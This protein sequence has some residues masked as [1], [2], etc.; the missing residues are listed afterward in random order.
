MFKNYVV[1]AFRNLKKNKIFS[2]INIIGLALGISCGLA[3]FMIV[4]NELNFD[5]FHSNYNHI[6][7]IVTEVRYPEGK[8]YT[9]G[10]PLPLPDAIRNDFPEIA[11]TRIYGGYNN[12]LDVL[13]D[14][15]VFTGK[16]FKE[17][18]GV[19]YTEATFFKMF[20]FKW[21]YGN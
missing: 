14:K 11:V 20:N 6:Y 10:T 17:E 3:I 16:R 7:R 19:F 18:D 8:E 13:N 21:L 1:V 4:R 9:P 5:T 12:Q 2:I 15:G